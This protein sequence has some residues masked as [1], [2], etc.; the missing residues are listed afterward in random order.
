VTGR[1]PP[2]ELPGLH[3]D[4]GDFHSVRNVWLRLPF[5]RFTCRH[6]C[7]LEAFGVADVAHFTEH[8]DETHARTCPGPPQ[9]ESA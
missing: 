2:T 4:C 8:I 6:G 7:D 1:W 9:K 5:A 3:V